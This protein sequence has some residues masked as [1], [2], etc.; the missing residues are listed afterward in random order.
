HVLRNIR[1]HR[2]DLI[3]DFQGLFKTSLLTLAL[4][5]PS[6]S[7]GWY[8]ARE[9]LSSIIHTKTINPTS[10]ENII[11]K[12]IQLACGAISLLTNIPIEN[13]KITL[14][15]KSAPKP[16]TSAQQKIAQWFMKNKSNRFIILTPNTTWASKHWPLLRWQELCLILSEKITDHTVVLVG[17]NFGQQGSQLASFIND[18]NLPIIVAPAW[19]LNELFAAM[20]YT[21]LLV[22]PDTGLLHIADCLGVATIGLYGPTKVERH[23]PQISPYNRSLCFQVDCIH[24]YQKTHGDI[25][26]TS[27]AQDCM[28]KL[29][30]YEVAERIYS[31]I[32]QK[33]FQKSGDCH[34]AYS[35]TYPLDL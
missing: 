27:Q 11:E 23:A 7:F 10:S 19:N 35:H 34:A 26:N 29:S 24:H 28:Y 22:A 16:S 17:Q 4:D 3:I 6:I 8:S 9:K 14:P 32:A 1:T 2:Y 13:A 20:K 15:L 21:D 31:A 33:T 5:I 25:S 18:R 12:N 30:A